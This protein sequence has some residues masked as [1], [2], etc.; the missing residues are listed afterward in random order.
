MRGI[1]FLLKAKD[2]TQ[3]VFKK[4]D[5]NL[6]VLKQK[7][8]VF[9]KQFLDSQKQVIKS[10]NTIQ[11]DLKKVEQI[12]G[13][14]SKLKGIRLIPQFDSVKRGFNQIRKKY[15]ELTQKKGVVQLV[16][17]FDKA[18]N[19]IADLNKKLQKL[20]KEK[21]VS[22]SKKKIARLN[23]EIDKTE[24][25]LNKL[26]NTGRKIDVDSSSLQTAKTLILSVG[27]ALGAL[28]IG[29]NVVS[30]FQ[31]LKKVSSQVRVE[32]G[33][34]QQTL[35]VT[36][37]ALTQ[38]TSKSQAMTKV[39]KV[40]NQD[41]IAGV[42]A[43]KNAYEGMTNVQ[44]FEFIKQGC[45]SGANAHGGFIDKLKEYP[46]FFAQAGLSAKESIAF[47]SIMPKLG[48][49]SDKGADTIKESVLRLKEMP[50]A[51]GDALKQ[52]FAVS[53]KNGGLKINVEQF[54]KGLKTGE[55]SAIGASRTISKALQ[56][57]DK[58]T[59]QVVLADVFGGA[60]EDAGKFVDKLHEID[61]NLDKQV[62]KMNPLV[63]KQMKQLKL[64]EN[65]SSEAQKFAP[66]FNKMSDSGDS[67]FGTLQLKAYQMVNDL[68]PTFET[69]G[70]YIENPLIPTIEKFF[71][72]VRLGVA[73]A[74]N[75][76]LK[77]RTNIETVGIVVLGASAIWATYSNRVAVSNA[78]DKAKLVLTRLKSSSMNFLNLQT[79]RQNALTALSTIRM[80]ANNAMTFSR[81]L[82]TGQLGAAMQ[83][84]N[85]RQTALNAKTL[86]STVITG[87]FSG[88]MTLLN[89]TLYANPIGLVILAIAS[90]TGM[91]A[92]A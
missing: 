81:L 48:I 62:D 68:Q 88:A 25:A 49:Y 18:K 51:A 89:A 85:L 60:G 44:A 91:I 27:V 10:A 90:F 92:L 15:H 33:L 43:L 16:P 21:E 24:K 64:Q 20:Q 47:M 8:K 66:L 19:S 9:G 58:Q 61:L 5:S 67:F 39:F 79:L 26:T 87:G 40:E 29:A 59:R 77:V 12:I 11:A 17:H 50:K 84:L 83:M 31:H 54:K 55:I 34:L 30:S 75:N 78:I 28:T 86:L 65:L 70:K 22:V 3:G 80:G 57:V 13:N 38:T 82:I 1:E 37:K 69:I 73:S 4:I 6:S 71:D 74:Q 72:K 35:G 63:A 46:T 56:H 76:W 53:A 41:L 14:I 36:G 52:L 42:S 2:K 23:R 7:A 32:Q 45:L